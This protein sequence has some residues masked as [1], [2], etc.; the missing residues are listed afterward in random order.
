MN[1][2]E[3]ENSTKWRVGLFAALGLLLL[4]VITLFVN[5]KPYWWNSCKLVN[6]NVKDAT[7]LRMK[8]PVR[9]LGLQIGYIHKVELMGTYVRLSICLTAKVEVNENTRA[10]IRPEG[11]LGDQFVELRPVRNLNFPAESEAPL[12]TTPA[13]ESPQSFWK[14]GWGVMMPTAHAE[15]PTKD[16]SANPPSSA[17]NPA[18]SPRKKPR[19]ATTTGEGDRPPEVP[20]GDGN[21]NINEV[22]KKV[23]GLVSELSGLATNLKSAIDPDKLRMTMDQLNKTLENAAKTLSPEGGLTSTAQ[24]T[25]AKLED[26]IEQLRQ[27]MTKINQGEGSVGMVVNDPSYAEELKMAVKNINL[28][29]NK[30]SAMRIVIDVGA[31]RLTAYK[32]SRA[33]VHVGIWPSYDRYYL[34]GLA[35]DPRG[36]TTTTVT[37]TEAAGVSS[38]TKTTQNEESGLLL[39]AMLG[40]VF[41]NRLDLSLGVHYGDGAGRVAFWVGPRGDESQFVLYDE[42]YSQSVSRGGQTGIQNRIGLIANPIPARYFR[43]VYVTG[44]LDSFKK[45]QTKVNYFVGAGIAFDDNDIKLLFSFL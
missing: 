29:L 40:K 8:S 23:D 33:T 43:N 5:D 35:I 42:V 10:Y 38:T 37:T 17:A 19:P 12:E 32:D 11:F 44:G 7:G 36:K 9:S 20:M 18:Q 24:R 45:Y 41:F 16:I 39:T 22:V 6:I 26:S 14:R 13:P 21:E 1:V 31:S 28:L 25:L 3:V 27:I 4:A 2:N 15:T 30:A 34:L